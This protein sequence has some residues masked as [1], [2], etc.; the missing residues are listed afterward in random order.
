MDFAWGFAVSQNGSLH[1]GIYGWLV[2]SLPTQVYKPWFSDR[3]SSSP[4]CS[5]PPSQ[6]LCIYLSLSHRQTSNCTVLSWFVD[7][8]VRLSKRSHTY[9]TIAAIT[10]RSWDFYEC[11]HSGIPSQSSRPD[12]AVDS[13]HPWESRNNLHQWLARW[14]ITWGANGSYFELASWHPSRNSLPYWLTWIR[15]G[16]LRHASQC[17]PYPPDSSRMIQI[18]TRFEK[19]IPGESPTQ[20]RCGEGVV[21]NEIRN[22]TNRKFSGRLS[23]CRREGTVFKI[24]NRSWPTTP[25][26]PKGQGHG[27]HKLVARRNCCQCV[28]GLITLITLID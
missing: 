1:E 26:R 27:S 21:A 11:A 2:I 20:V 12:T 3:K 28:K 15:I 13:Q 16:N 4:I 17:Q 7:Q 25:P 5:S 14:R 10:R 9:R 22:N 19:E 6:A 8:K 24:T 23:N 18:C